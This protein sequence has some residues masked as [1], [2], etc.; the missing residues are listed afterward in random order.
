MIQKLL[1]RNHLKT[2]KAGKPGEDLAE[3][4]W[5]YTTKPLTSKKNEESRLDFQTST[6]SVPEEIGQ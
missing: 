4:A 5:S 2:A 1:I 6:M 3:G